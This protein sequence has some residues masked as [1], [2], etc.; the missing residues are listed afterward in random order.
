MMTAANRG[1]RLTGWGFVV[2]TLASL[3]WIAV[4]LASGETSLV[5]ANAVLTLINMIGIWRWL[6]LQSA[7]EDGAGAAKRASRRTA[8]PALFTATGL[9]GMPVVSADGEAIGTVVEALI[10]CRSARVSYVVV[11]TTGEWL[12]DETCRAVPREGITFQSDRL[13]L[14]LT[15]AAFCTLLPLPRGDWPAA[16]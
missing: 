15:R 1:A 11:A 4:G 9:A 16:V 14:A 6:G 3:C 2:F 13:V 10:E 7:R 8:S 12:L 5:V